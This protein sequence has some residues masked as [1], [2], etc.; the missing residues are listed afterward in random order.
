[1]ASAQ[2]R[3]LAPEKARPTLGRPESGANDLDFDGGTDLGMQP[4]RNLV[5]ANRLDRVADLDLAAV[6]LGAAGVLDGR[7]NVGRRDRPEQ[8]PAAA[9]P[10]VQPHAQPGETLGRSL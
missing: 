7:G 6:Q 8:P 10:H 5:R 4:D 3:A 2:L 1:M 9:G